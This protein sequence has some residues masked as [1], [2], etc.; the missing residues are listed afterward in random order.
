MLPKGVKPKIMASD[1]PKAAAFE[2]PVVKGLAILLPVMACMTRPLMPRPMPETSAMVMR[3]RR[4][5]M[6]TVSSV[7][8]S[9]AAPIKWPPGSRVANTR[10][11]VTL[12]TPT[13]QLEKAAM[14]KRIT[15]ASINAALFL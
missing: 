11:T 6:S 13:K 4:S 7:W 8:F 14:I 3:G 5:C 10:P 1:A 15:A 9:A 12:A 2:S